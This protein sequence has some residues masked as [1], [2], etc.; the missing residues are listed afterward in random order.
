MVI[1]GIIMWSG[2]IATIPS[3]YQLCDGTNGTPDL[4]NQFVACAQQDHAGVPKS[5]LDGALNQSGGSQTHTH[6]HAAG[7]EI[8]DTPPIG[9]LE[10]AMTTE[11]NN[12][13]WY[14]LAYIQRMS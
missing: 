2:T 1:G 8:P 9:N 14:S 6:T 10:E 4:R 3:N 12:P 11:Y 13:P 7:I 5:I